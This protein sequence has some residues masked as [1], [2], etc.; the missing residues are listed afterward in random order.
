MHITEQ[1]VED[2]VKYFL[3]SGRKKDKV[4][5]F[6]FVFQI[7]GPEDIDRFVLAYGDD[8]GDQRQ[9]VKG[10]Y[11]QMLLEVSAE[12]SLALMSLQTPQVIYRQILVKEDGYTTKLAELG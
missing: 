4:C 10:E 1:Q 5:P 11:A 3:E 7:E 12:I 9:V 8:T 2:Y 6:L